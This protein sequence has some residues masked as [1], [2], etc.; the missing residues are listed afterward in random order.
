MG[1]EDGGWNEVC[2]RNEMRC[3]ET[4]IYKGGE[5]VEVSRLTEIETPTVVYGC[6]PFTLLVSASD[7]MMGAG[8]P[9]DRE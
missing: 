2:F 4:Y 7:L 5:G 9:F 8:G 3:W 1:E 6:T